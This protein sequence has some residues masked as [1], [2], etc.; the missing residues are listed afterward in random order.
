MLAFFFD[1]TV[2]NVFKNK[3][4]LEEERQLLSYNLP[5]LA[6]IKF[7]NDNA[8]EIIL[9]KYPTHYRHL[10]FGQYNIAFAGYFTILGTLSMY[11][12][13]KYIYKYNSYKTLIAMS[14][15]SLICAQ[16]AYIGY[17]RVKD[18]KSIILKNGKTIVI[19]TFQDGNIKYETDLKDIRITNKETNDLLILVDVNHAKSREFRFFFAEPSPGTVNNLNLFQTVFLDQR[20][21]KY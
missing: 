17:T 20:Y 9:F 4:Q 7:N 1:S 16:E 2:Y 3:W 15:I 11:V 12:G 19:E 18:V 10:K 21:I 5:K 6:K 13:L 8:E 14:I